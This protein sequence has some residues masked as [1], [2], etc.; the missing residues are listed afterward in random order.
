MKITG[1]AIPFNTPS[2][3]LGFIEVFNSN[4]I[5]FANDV[6]CCFG[7]DTKQLLGR[8]SSGTLKLSQT[9]KG[10]EYELDLPE[11]RAD[12]AELIQRGDLTR[13]SFGFTAVDDYIEDDIWP[14][15]R[16]INQATLHEISIVPL[17]SYDSTTINIVKGLDD[18][19]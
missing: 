11:S 7:H 5:T 9:D 17:A 3:N 19:H 13:M 12:I 4:S 10:I 18:E 15:V 1:L 6:L 8:T 14:I 16:Y 2:D